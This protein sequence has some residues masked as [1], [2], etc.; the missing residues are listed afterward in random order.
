[1][2]LFDLVSD[3]L[4]AMTLTRHERRTRMRKKRTNGLRLKKWAN[5]THIVTIRGWQWKK[6]I[7][8]ATQVKNFIEPSM[9]CFL[10]L[11]LFALSS[12]YTVLSDLFHLRGDDISSSVTFFFIYTQKYVR[13]YQ[14]I[15]H[16]KI[17]KIGKMS[18]VLCS[19]IIL[20]FSNY[21]SALFTG[22]LF[23]FK[24]LCMQVMV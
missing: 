14:K 13:G 20:K 24:F 2:I 3:I 15:A 8:A 1:M 4:S 23:W 7:S 5:S 11:G 22:C 21:Y 19:K 9:F 10:T 16:G 18:Y 6:Y 12:S 17:T